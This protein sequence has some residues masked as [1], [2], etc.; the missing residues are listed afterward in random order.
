MYLTLTLNK[1][2]LTRRTVMYCSTHF[3]QLEKLPDTLQKKIEAAL[4]GGQP[5]H[6]PKAGANTGDGAS[7]SIAGPEKKKMK[8]L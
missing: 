7:S 5:A 8:R 3:T 4:G 1:Y 6:A 2:T